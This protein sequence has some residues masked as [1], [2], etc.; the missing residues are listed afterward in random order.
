MKLK[1]FKYTKKKDNKTKNYFIML[2]EESDDH[3]GGIDFSK[4]EEDEIKRATDIQKKIE[5]QHLEWTREAEEQDIKL[6]TYLESKSSEKA[7]LEEE[8]KPY[9]KK[10]YRKFLVKNI[11]TELGEGITV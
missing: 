2:L 9:V 11:S 5:A 8:L 10:A 7:K 3:I 4:L 1:S 6:D